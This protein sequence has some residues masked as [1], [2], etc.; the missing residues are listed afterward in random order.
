MLEFLPAL[1]QREAIAFGDG[2]AL[3]VRIKFNELDKDSLPRSS[4]AKFSEKW[5]VSVEDVSFLDTVVERWRSSNMNVDDEHEAA[6]EAGA[7]PQAAQ[8]QPQAAQPAAPRAPAPRAPQQPAL[9]RP[10]AAP[11]AQ[12]PAM[13]G[14]AAPAQQAQPQGSSIA[15]GSRLR[16]A[17]APNQSSGAAGGQAQLVS[18]EARASLRERLL[19]PQS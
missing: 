13:A 2:V 14:A 19:K 16:K 3:P 1:G 7:E 12:Q 10:A 6:A 8:P 5:Q 17:N 4:T 15:A 11:Q 9:R 18:A